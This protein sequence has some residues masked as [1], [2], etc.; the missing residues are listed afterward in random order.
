MAAANVKKQAYKLD[1][2]VMKSTFKVAP[3]QQ[4]SRGK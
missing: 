1:Y 2:S 3:R 4:I